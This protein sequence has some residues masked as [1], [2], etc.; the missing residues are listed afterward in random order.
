MALQNLNK[1][2]FETISWWLKKKGFIEKN[3]QAEKVYKTGNQMEN[4]MFV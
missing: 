4:A 1:Q 2:T 3:L